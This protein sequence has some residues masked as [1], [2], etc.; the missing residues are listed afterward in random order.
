MKTKP[1]IVTRKA[2]LAAR[3][4]LRERAGR[5]TERDR[6]WAGVLAEDRSLNDRLVEI[7]V[8]VL[9][10]SAVFSRTRS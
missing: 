9:R 2:M 1:D 4:L 8:D 6:R 7:A 10:F 5:L 3:I